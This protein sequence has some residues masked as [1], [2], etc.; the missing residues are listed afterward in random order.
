[1]TYGRMLEV[2]ARMLSGHVRGDIPRY[3]IVEREVF[4]ELEHYYVFVD[5]TVVDPFLALSWPEFHKIYGGFLGP[6][7]AHRQTLPGN[8]DS[9]PGRGTFVSGDGGLRVPRE[10][11]HAEDIVGRL[12]TSRLRQRATVAEPPLET[13]AAAPCGARPQSAISA[14]FSVAE[15]KL[16][17][18]RILSPRRG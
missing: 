9:H 11:N 14:C 18:H 1:M 3:V 5:R 12:C 13:R 4:M 10:T 6:R 16:V 8:R 15:R 17:A 2:Q 7:S